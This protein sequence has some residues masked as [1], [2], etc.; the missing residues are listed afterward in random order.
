MT[1]SKKMLII[2]IGVV[3]EK[4]RLLIWSA[5]QKA[6]RKLL[7]T[8]PLIEDHA[9]CEDCGRN[10]HDFHVPDEIWIKVYGNEAGTLC[11]DCFCDRSDKMGMWY[12]IN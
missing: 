4:L 8:Y 9:R 1:Y 5:W 3:K 6:N 10:V 7:K 12:R 2:Y 11:Y